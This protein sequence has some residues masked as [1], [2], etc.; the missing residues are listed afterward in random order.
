MQPIFK[1]PIHSNLYIFF[2]ELNNVNMF[3]FIN[4]YFAYQKTTRQRDATRNIQKTQ[5]DDILK[6]NVSCSVEFRHFFFGRNFCDGRGVLRNCTS[7]SLIITSFMFIIVLLIKLVIE[8]GTI[9][10]V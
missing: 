4:F 6:I 8:S 1:N 5:K 3:R 9:L 7:L 10:S 2:P